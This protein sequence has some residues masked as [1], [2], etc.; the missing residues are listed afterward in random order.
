MHDAFRELA[1]DVEIYNLY[2]AHD[3][4]G[5]TADWLTIDGSRWTV[6]DSPVRMTGRTEFASRTFRGFFDRDR[7]VRL[8]D[9]EL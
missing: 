7:W 1:P 3:A 9:S 6:A 4:T 5:K 8:D 2:G